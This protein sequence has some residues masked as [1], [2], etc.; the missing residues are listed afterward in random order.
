MSLS[1]DRPGGLAPSMWPSSGVCGR[2]LCHP[3]SCPYTWPCPLFSKDSNKGPQVTGS[4]ILK[5]RM[6][7]GGPS[8]LEGS[9]VGVLGVDRF[10]A[11][12]QVLQRAGPLEE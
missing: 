2:E 1:H 9:R 7:G 4:V 6:K 11:Q 10:R 12:E 8:L 3:S 5:T